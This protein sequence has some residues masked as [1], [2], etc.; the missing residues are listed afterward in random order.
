[1]GCHCW[2]DKR[3]GLRVL[4]T[5]DSEHHIW[6]MQAGIIVCKLAPHQRAMPEQMLS[7]H[8]GGSFS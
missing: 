4:D 5:A 1:M 8:S 7:R 2:F 6:H 3:A